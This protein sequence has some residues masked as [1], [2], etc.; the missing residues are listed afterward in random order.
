VADLKA[1]S[2]NLMHSNLSITNGGYGILSSQDVGEKIA[3]HGGKA[4]KGEISRRRN[5]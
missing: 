1:V 5:C 2:Q 4:T 3:N